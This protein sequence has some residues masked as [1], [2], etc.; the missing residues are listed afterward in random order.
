MVSE[1][2]KNALHDLDRDERKALIKEALTEWLEKQWAAFG[3][4]TAK[5]IGAAAFSAGAYWWLTTH[6]WHK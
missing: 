4:W 3:K 1:E 5:G 6:G 2:E